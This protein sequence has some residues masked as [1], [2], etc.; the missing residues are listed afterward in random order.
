[1][2]KKIKDYKE[3]EDKTCESVLSLKDKLKTI[4]DQ[5]ILNTK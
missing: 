2:E 1:M 3:S 5:A 4:K